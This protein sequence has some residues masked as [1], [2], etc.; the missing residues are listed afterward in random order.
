MQNVMHR[1]TKRVPAPPTRRIVWVDGGHHADVE[2]GGDEG[3]GNA[4]GGAGCIGAT[5][6]CWRCVGA[7]LRKFCL[8][9]KERAEVRLQ[10][11]LSAA[12]RL[13]DSARE[14]AIGAEQGIPP[15]PPPV[16]QALSHV[17]TAQGSL[18]PPRAQGAH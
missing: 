18:L 8:R 17:V 5:A 14:D 2:A 7:S 1:Q 13:G 16:R 4:G 11:L 10:N 12:F 15:P 9:R 3:A 6:S